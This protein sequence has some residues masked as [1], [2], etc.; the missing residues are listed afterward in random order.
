MSET[1]IIIVG[2][3]I[4][5]VAS[6]WF[7]ARRGARNVVL[8]EREQNLGTQATAQNAAILRTSMPD[9]LS[10]ELARESASFLRRPPPGFSAIPLIDECGVVI[11]STRAANEKPDWQRRLDARAEHGRDG[12]PPDVERLTPSRLRAIAPHLEADVQSAWLLRREGRIDNAALMH[13]F[14]SGARSLGVKFETES[15]VRAIATERSGESECVARALGVELADGRVLRAERTLIA[16]GGWAEPLG[17][18][19]GS[20]VRLRPTRRHLLVTDVDARVDARWPVVWLDGD[21]FYARPESGGLMLCACD[22][23]DVDP[24]ALCSLSEEREHVLAKTARFLP[25]FAD[26]R[27]AH[28][29][30]GVRTLTQD[31]RFVIGRDADVDGLCWVAGLGGHGMTCSA[32]IG[33]LAA[34]ILLDGASAHPAARAVDPARFSARS[35]STSTAVPARR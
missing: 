3:G 16:A 35:S 19:A 7:L 27:A 1:S 26:V 11:A 31:D 5:G 17:R 23:V 32:A 20:R 18:A 10:E 9:A 13:A 25:R 29:W 24:D 30:A 34:D 21:P 33:K 4:A 8:V 28:F 15:P 12:E 2:G 22:E 6:A 14:E